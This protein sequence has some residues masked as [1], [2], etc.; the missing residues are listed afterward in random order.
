M[1]KPEYKSRLIDKTIDEYLSVAKAVCVEGPKWCGKTWTCSYHAASEYLVGD[2]TNNFTNRRLAELA[3]L[4][5]LKGARPRLIDEWQEVPSLWDAVRMTVDNNSEKGQY[6]MTGS[7]TPVNKGVMYSGT[8]RIVKIRMHTMSLF[9]S[10]DSDGRIS[11]R[12]V[13]SDDFNDTVFTKDVSLEH[14][15]YLIVRG[16]WPDNIGVDAS[17]AGILPG[18]YLENVVNE[19]I[20]RL[21]DT[22]KFE[23]EK[24]WLLL[25]S[26]ARNESTM[27]SGAA[28]SRDVSESENETLSDDTI[29]KYI[30]AFSR[31]FL[32]ENQKPFSPN[33]RSSLRVR[34]KEKRHFCDPALACGALGIT[35]S[36]LMKDLDMFGFLFEALVERD[37]RIYAES[38][39]AELFHYRDDMNNEIDAVIEMNDGEWCGIE[40]KLGANKIDE[41]AANL[42]KIKK[43]ITDNGGRPPKALCVVCGLTNAA[44]RRPDGVTVVPVTSLKN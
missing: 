22:V 19:D 5:V 21:D 26:L 9:E 10:G 31:L 29:A 24:L 8:G 30:D 18:S 39:G 32:L 25:R 6:L 36:R 42:L 43:V 33:I 37:L 27:V 28:L 44:Y 35:P 34:Q 4:E 20:R 13:C 3:P 7:S 41:A 17:K 1:N 11:L 16:G 40:I 12:D 2:P 23:T 14:L 38:F 15:A